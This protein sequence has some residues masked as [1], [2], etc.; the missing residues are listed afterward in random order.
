[1]KGGAEDWF[2]FWIRLVCG[3]LFFGPLLALITFRYA[4]DIG[5]IQGAGITL[6]VTLPLCLFV[7][8]GGSRA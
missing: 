4:H 1:M 7:A 8:R 6:L 3:L 5:L 2:E